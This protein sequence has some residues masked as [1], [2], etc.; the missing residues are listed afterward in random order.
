MKVIGHRQAARWALVAGGAMALGG[1]RAPI[2]YVVHGDGVVPA[3]IGGQAARV[4]IS[5][6]APAAP[7]LNPEFASAIGLHGGM[8]GFS[9]KV[10][11]VKVGAQSSVTRLE[12]G[13]AGFKRR[14][15]WFDRAYARGADAAVGP[16][17]LPVD[18][19]RFQLRPPL[20][21][22]RTV[23]LPLVQKMFQ[24][25]YA[26]VVVGG[27]AL[28]VL[29]DPQH[30]RSLATAG[31]GQSIAAVYGGQLTGEAGQAEVAFGIM[32]PIRTM[33]LNA[34]LLVGPLR[35][36]AVTV[37]IGDNGT[38]AGIADANADPDEI[39]VTAR[40]NN[41][42]RDTLIVGRDQLAHCSSIVFD[43]PAR[44]IRLTCA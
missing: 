37:R 18:I 21:G 25:T 11:P 8:F 34:P 4:R 44:Q 3:R 10:G 39:V 38:T 19:V 14:V 28:A 13:T 9:V 17:G 31:A 33:R 30:D 36:D 35:F 32:R 41:N 42:R 22:E 20:A 6:W 43:K 12:L 40:G 15:V 16:G 29:F 2:D 23:A 5:P 7:T 27:R 26:Q 1:A 24:P